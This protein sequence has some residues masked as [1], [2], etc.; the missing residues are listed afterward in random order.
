MQ[1]LLLLLEC[2]C[3]HVAMPPAYGATAATNTYNNSSSTSV[4]STS[5]N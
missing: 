3:V 5:N 1:M 2:V 4:R